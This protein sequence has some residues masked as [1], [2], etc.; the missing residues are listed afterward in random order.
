MT[1]RTCGF[2]LVELVIVV[3]VIGIIATAAM[4]AF[5]TFVDTRRLEGVASQVASDLQFARSEAV[6]R[7]EGVR[8]SFHQGAGCYVVHTGAAGQCLCSAAGT[9]QCEG[10][11]RALKTSALDDSLGLRLH[12]NVASIRFDPLHGTASPTATVRLSSAHGRAIHHVVN[13]MGRVRS[14]SPQGVVGRPRAC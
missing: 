13:L 3:A 4:P 1:T 14:C 5:A 7:N 2:T 9:S 11:A 12:S 10:D 6:L 8:V